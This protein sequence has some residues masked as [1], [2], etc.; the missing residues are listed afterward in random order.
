MMMELQHL[1]KQSD[2][3]ICYI[4][5]FSAMQTID[6]GNGKQSIQTDELYKTL[7]NLCYSEKIYKV[8]FYGNEEYIEGIA[9][10]MF[11][12]EVT[13]YGKNI[14]EIEVN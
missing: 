9:S 14:I 2:T 4:D 13:H 5:M 8:H 6:Y 10:D 1:A 12:D 7:N 11:A 3:I